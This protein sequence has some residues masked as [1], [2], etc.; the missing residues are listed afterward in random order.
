MEEP[1]D[2]ILLDD[3]PGVHHAVYP[4][5]WYIGDKLNPNEGGQAPKGESIK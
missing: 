1:K 2:T 4:T 5:G 3:M